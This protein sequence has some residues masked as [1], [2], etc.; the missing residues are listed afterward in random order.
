MNVL[1][2]N[3]GSSSIKFQLIETNTARIAAHTDRAIMRGQVEK[4]GSG[5]SVVTVR[6]GDDPPEQ[7]GG[8]LLTHQAALTRVFELLK[9]RQS[10]VE[11]IGHRVVHG[12]ERMTESR[13]I[14]PDVLRA[15]EAAI[16]LAPLHNPANLK[17][18]KVCRGLYP[19]LP[20][21][22]V[23]DTA[24]HHTLPRQAFLYAL[25]YDYYRKQGIRR[26]GFHGTSVRYVFYRYREITGTPREKANLIV[27]HLGNG[28]SI[29]A[30]K[31]GKSV[32]TSMGFTPLEGLVMGTRCGDIDPSILLHLMTR[33]E[34]APH[35]ISTFLNRW[36][37]LFGLSGESND[38]RTLLEHVAEGDE[39]CRMAV[40]VFCYRLRKY[41]GAYWAAVGRLDAVIFTG[42]IG[43]NA[44]LVRAQTVEGLEELG[45]QIDPVKNA[46]RGEI[47]ISAESS[48]VKTWVIPTNE[49]LLIARDTFRILNGLPLP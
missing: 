23:F 5:E 39:R 42:G 48:R 10:P 33:D 12:G 38:M 37:G 8:E 4:I 29:T 45:L 17:G 47:D 26:Y 9:E 41:I 15:V 24:F 46:G 3:C 22:A 2:L 43:E 36:C 40:E 7:L 18:Y 6:F 34:L 44:A 31:D 25:P 28:C 11:A 13:E 35:E 19:E 32:D 21:V 14:T 27:C 20:Q 1:V 16:P 30:I 49:E